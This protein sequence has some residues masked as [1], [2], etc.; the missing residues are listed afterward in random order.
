MLLC[1]SA[2]EPPC[3]DLCGGYLADNMGTGKTVATAALIAATLHEATAPT[4][5]VCPTVLVK[6]WLEELAAWVPAATCVRIAGGGTGLAQ[7][8]AAARPTVAV[9]S[10]GVLARLDVADAELYRVVFDEAHT[11]SHARPPSPSHVEKGIVPGRDTLVRWCAGPFSLLTLLRLLT[12]LTLLTLTLFCCPRHSPCR[13]VPHS[14]RPAAGPCPA[15]P[16]P[17]SGAST[18]P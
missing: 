7:Q 17:E 18:R 4:L 6:Q 12:L 1:C 15:R 16:C 3:A 2:E 10:Y 5:V 13:R 14:R 8:L 9:V 11:L